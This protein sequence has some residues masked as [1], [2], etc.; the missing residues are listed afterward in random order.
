MDLTNI[1]IVLCTLCLVTID[2]IRFHLSPNQKKCLREEIHKDVLVTGDYEVSDAPGQKAN[3]MVSIALY[4][5]NFY[6]ITEIT[7]TILSVHSV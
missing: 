2:A 6:I 7:S 5:G 1:F 3:L 4:Y